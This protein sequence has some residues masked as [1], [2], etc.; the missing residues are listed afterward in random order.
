MRCKTSPLSLEETDDYIQHRLNIAGARS[1][2]IFLREAVEAVHAHSGGI[3][4]IVNLLCADALASADLK[5]VQKVSLQMIEEAAEKTN[6]SVAKSSE[7]VVHSSI[8]R[9]ATSARFG[10]APSQN[11]V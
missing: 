3:P 7:H 9:N 8:A 6:L 1:K 5:E 10:Y 11:L 2:S 4:R